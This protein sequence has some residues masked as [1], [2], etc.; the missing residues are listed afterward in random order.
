MQML[1]TETMPG[2]FNY[3]IVIVLM[4]I[5]FYTVIAHDNLVKK[6]IGLNIFQTS[7]FIFY[8]SMGQ[9]TGSTAPILMHGAAGQQAVYAHPLPQV[10][11]L[12]AIV[13]G[14]STTALA[15]AL[16]VR[17]HEAYGSIEE[18]DILAADYQRGTQESQK[19]QERMARARAAERHASRDADDGREQDEDAPDS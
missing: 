4:M 9:I 5:G 1:L 19:E 18:D 12:T 14:L 13:V 16:V 11:I 2:L 10:L 3:W 15:L 6:I 7:V 17:I 8:I